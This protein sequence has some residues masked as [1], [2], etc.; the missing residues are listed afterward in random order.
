[1]PFGQMHLLNISRPAVLRTYYGVN[2]EQIS[3]TQWKRVT[4]GPINLSG[5]L[6]IDPRKFC[7]KTMTHNM[8][9]LGQCLRKHLKKICKERKLCGKLFDC[10]LN[11][12][13]ILVY[14]THMKKN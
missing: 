4:Y 1:M 7:T 2:V 12:C 10:E 11:H 14:N 9:Y 8:Y 13:T 5:S 6:C 3:P